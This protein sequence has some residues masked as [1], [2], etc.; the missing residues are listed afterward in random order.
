MTKVFKELDARK[1]LMIYCDELKDI[2]VE[3]ST[4]DEKGKEWIELSSCEHTL[5]VTEKQKLEKLLS[6]I[7]FKE[8]VSTSKPTSEINDLIKSQHLK[9]LCEN[10]NGQLWIYFKDSSEY[11]KL[12]TLLKPYSSTRRKR[13]F[14][15]VDTCSSSAQHEP[16]L[17]ESQLEWRS[18]DA[19]DNTSVG[20]NTVFPTYL[21]E[22]VI[23]KTEF[24][25]N[26]INTKIYQGSIVK[27]RVGAIVNAANERLDNCGGVADVIAKAA[28]YK[29]EDDCREKMKNG[30]RIKVSENVVTCAG[31]LPCRWII[32]AVGPRWDDY[33]YKVK[34]LEDLYKTVFNVLKTASESHMQS[35][36][37]P[38][39]SSGKSTHTLSCFIIIVHV[40]LLCLTL[41][42]RVL[43][44]YRTSLWLLVI[45]LLE[46][47]SELCHNN[48]LI[49]RKENRSLRFKLFCSLYVTF[50]CNHFFLFFYEKKMY[51]KN[52]NYSL[53]QILNETSCFIHIFIFNTCNIIFYIHRSSSKLHC[54]L[55]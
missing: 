53:C 26:G 5:F 41:I 55:L 17:Y 33:F 51:L 32:H 14:G 11:Q 23:V 46:K 50:K 54:T 24:A 4:S 15:N 28:G 45:F 40:P 12:Q 34:A 10:E 9:L 6:K 27:A 38:P 48:L 8:I 1:L 37:M 18:K 25:L 47:I 52:G 13:T 43:K 20:D 31:N 3:I 22:N 19:L 42:V 39:I 30:K 49:T 29:M 35:V 44:I 7:E 2:K 16:N 21:G 36:V